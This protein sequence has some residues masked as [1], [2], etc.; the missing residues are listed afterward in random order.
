M[1]KRLILSAFLA[2]A[3]VVCVQTTAFADDPP[4]P[5]PR[6]YY[7]SMRGLTTEAVAS[8]VSLTRTEDATHTVAVDDEP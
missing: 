6:V 5:H 3:A 8:F 7:V 1:H 2:S 4:Q